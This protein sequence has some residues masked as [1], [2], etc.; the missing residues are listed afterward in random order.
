MPEGVETVFICE[1]IKSWFEERDVHKTGF[2]D[3]SIKRILQPRIFYFSP[4]NIREFNIRFRRINYRNI[5]SFGKN[6]IFPS[7]NDHALYFEM[8]MTGIFKEIPDEYLAVEFLCENKYPFYFSDKRKYSYLMLGNKSAKPRNLIHSM[9]VAFDWRDKDLA[10]KASN[11]IF[12]KDTWMEKNIKQVLTNPQIISGIGNIYANEGLFD[13]GTFPGKKIKDMDKEEVKKCINKCQEIMIES[14]NKG[15]LTRDTVENYNK[16]AYGK[17]L[18]RVYRKHGSVCPK[19]KMAIIQKIKLHRTNS[20]FC[21]LCQKDP[22]N[23]Y[24]Q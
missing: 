22:Y 17:R 16:L 2:L 14:Y 11:K 18:L 9:K 12:S 13:S 23:E 7:D 19:C 1:D 4:I 10:E 5:Y 21:P 24:E 20:Y 15:G 3:F 8:G 6:I